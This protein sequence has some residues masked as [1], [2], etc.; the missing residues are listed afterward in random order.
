MSSSD[1]LAIKKR[2]NIQA[3]P[4]SRSSSAHLQ[5]RQYYLLKNAIHL[6]EDGEWITPE[7]FHISL[8]SECAFSFLWNN[9]LVHGYSSLYSIPRIHVPEY[10]K[11]RYQPSFCWT[12]FTPYGEILNEIACS[13][14]DGIPKKSAELNASS[15]PHLFHLIKDETINIDAI[16]N[17]FENSDA[18]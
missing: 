18:F 17:D 5:N 10:I 9:R 13:V 8:N 6:D 1:Y 11:N 3:Y 15:S 7:R 12:C 2:K 14:C 16:I 4:N